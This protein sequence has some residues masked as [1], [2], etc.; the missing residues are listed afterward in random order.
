MTGGVS[1]KA[2]QYVVLTYP[3]DVPNRMVES[4]RS[5]E[6][7]TEWD[8]EITITTEQAVDLYNQLRTALF[9]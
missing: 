3:R 2:G 8:T 9:D 1:A 6:Y 5:E 7:H 4:P